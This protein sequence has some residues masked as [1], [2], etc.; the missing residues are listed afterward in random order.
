L[1]V[2]DAG[3]RTGL[4]AHLFAAFLIE[5]KMDFAQCS[6]V[7]PALKVVVQRASRRQIPGDVTPLTP[8]AQ[9]V[10]DAIQHIANVDLTSSATAFGW[11]DQVLYLRPLVI[12]QV[13]RVTEL[14][15][16]VPVTVFGRPH[17]APRESVPVIES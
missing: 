5:F 8:R 16:V 6:I 7:V 17:Q 3:G 4:S 13:T 12:G 11:W 10:H 9:D 15:P 1:T 14:V 2:N